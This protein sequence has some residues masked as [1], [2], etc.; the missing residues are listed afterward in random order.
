MLSSEFSARRNRKL[1]L[2]SPPFRTH[3]SSLRFSCFPL[4]AVAFRYC[5]RRN[6]ALADCTK[7]TTAIH[8]TTTT[9]AAALLTT[10]TPRAPPRVPH[11]PQ[12]DSSQEIVWEC[13]DLSFA[14]LPVLMPRG[15]VKLQDLLVQVL[16]QLHDCRLV[17]ASI[18]VV[19]G[20]EEREHTC[21]QPSCQEP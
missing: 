4:W 13:F 6:A 5:S 15:R 7:K 1:G 9:T 19:G 3:E 18:A 16:V 8:H 10:F 14:E 11:V 20:R 12:P 21:I 17:S 2:A